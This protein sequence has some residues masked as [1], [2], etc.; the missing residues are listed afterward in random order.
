[1]FTKGATLKK[2]MVKN[3]EGKDIFFFE[4]YY[5][6][7]NKDETYFDS[8]L[9]FQLR[10][11]KLMDQLEALLN[12]NLSDAERESKAKTFFDLI[13]KYQFYK[14]YYYTEEYLNKQGRLHMPTL[15][16]FQQKAT[17]QHKMKIEV[18][19]NINALEPHSDEYNA[20][21]FIM[22][23]SEFYTAKTELMKIS[24]EISKH[25]FEKEL[26]TNMLKDAYV[27]IHSAKNKYY[28]CGDEKDCTYFILTGNKF[29]LFFDKP[30]I[31]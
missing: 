18:L 25:E 15:Q 19:K 20:R 27:A 2:W 11:T 10:H 12:I 6:D 16:Y 14:K 3:G 13:K 28:V 29:K 21:T 5:L 17:Q 4:L 23:K 22:V 31:T 9:S 1:M 24:R 7:A 8:N 30:K 26:K